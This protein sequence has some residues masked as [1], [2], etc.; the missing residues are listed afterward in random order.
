MLEKY[1]NNKS[2]VELEL[3]GSIPEENIST[4]IPFI[5]EE[6]ITILDIYILIQRIKKSSSSGIIIKLKNINI[7]L[8][9]ADEIRTLLFELRSD[10][11]S[12]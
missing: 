9:R 10:G 12:G 11:R 5:N 3:S 6:R 4:G 2:F 8:A 1:L 7:G